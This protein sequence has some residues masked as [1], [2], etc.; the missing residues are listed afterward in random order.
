MY[1]EA[2]HIK[3]HFLENPEWKTIFFKHFHNYTPHNYYKRAME[4]FQKN[5]YTFEIIQP[6]KGRTCHTIREC[7]LNDPAGD[8]VLGIQSSD[9]RA[10]IEQ[11]LVSVICEYTIDFSKFK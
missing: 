2:E 6:Y 1:L 5:G 11:V 8:L 9:E 3:N 10:S 4:I 7:Q